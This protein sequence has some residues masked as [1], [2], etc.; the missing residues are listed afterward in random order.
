MANCRCLRH[1]RHRR[2]ARSG[3]PISGN[4]L[5]ND[6]DPDAG[7][8]PCKWW[9]IN[10]G[11]GSVGRRHWRYLRQPDPELLMVTFSYAVDQQQCERSVTLQRGE[12]LTETFSYT[13]SDGDG[14]RSTAT[15]VFTI[16]GTN[17]APS[18]GNDQ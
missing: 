18:A 4:V 2:S 1:H 7:T 15:L 17:D 3:T 6:S 9:P 14:G 11:A 12:S 16:H 8:V 13:I 10:A 5:L